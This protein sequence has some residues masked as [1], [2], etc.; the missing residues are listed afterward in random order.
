MLK[1]LGIETSCDETSVAIVTE[2]KKILSNKIASQIAEHQ[3]YGGVV[4]EV[5][6]R[7]HM[8][9]LDQLID[10]AIKESNCSWQNIDA[11][12]VTAGP[13][14]IG[15]V[16]VGVMYAKAMASALNKPIIAINHLEGHALTARLTAEIPFPFLTLLV[17]GGHTQF[18]VVKNVGDY[19]ILGTTIDDALGEAFDKSAKMLGLGYP[20]G[21]ALEKKANNGDSD[22]FK[23]PKPLCNVKNCDFSFSGLKTA[24]KREIEKLG[25]KDSEQNICD[26]SASFQKTTAEILAIKTKQAMKEFDELFPHSTKSF[27]LSGGVAANKLIRDS[28]NNCCVDNGFEFFAPPISLC[29]D[30]AAMIAWAGIERYKLGIEDNINFQPKSRWPLDS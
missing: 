17:S 29:G 13:G 3:Q 12:A 5:A 21:P 16:I 15:G 4:P 2:D 28:L 6:S 26:V 10:S 9:H 8:R 27:V 22:R 20:G 25:D 11:I 18:L 1:I 24:V 14:L 7:S 30:N 19:K 23:F